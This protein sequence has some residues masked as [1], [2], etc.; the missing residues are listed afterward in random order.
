MKTQSYAVPV[1]V[2]L[3]IL[4]A[5]GASGSVYCF[6]HHVCMDGHM[7][8]PEMKR[9]WPWEYIIDALW[10]A[11]LLAVAVLSFV[12]HLRWMRWLALIFPAFLVYR[13]VL[14]SLGGP[15]RFPI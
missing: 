1:Y 4:V 6:H 13:F 11:S 10:S 7:A 15:F 5:I 14:G 3:L 2:G 8:H 12:F 9:Y